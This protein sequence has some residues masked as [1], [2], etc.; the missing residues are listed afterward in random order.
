[1]FFVLGLVVACGV[2]GEAAEEFSG[3]RVDDAN[4]E[5]IDE[6]DDMG[7]GVGSPDADVVECSCVAQ[8]DGPCV[9]ND[10]VPDPVVVVDV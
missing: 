8:G 2:K 9:S 10:V 6:H 3:S 4:V 1:M 7:S 5:V